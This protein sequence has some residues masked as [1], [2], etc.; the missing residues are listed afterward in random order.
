M[1]IISSEH[2][3]MKGKLVN[4]N[5]YQIQNNDGIPI[6]HGKI[7]KMKSGG[8]ICLVPLYWKTEVQLTNQ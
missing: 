2:L 7:F 1:H 4:S 3:N 6:S 8:L 5:L